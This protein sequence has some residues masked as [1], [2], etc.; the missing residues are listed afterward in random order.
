[1]D[2]LEAAVTLAAVVRD[3]LGFDDDDDEQL[4]ACAGGGCAR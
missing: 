4:P 1:M 2:R 3:A